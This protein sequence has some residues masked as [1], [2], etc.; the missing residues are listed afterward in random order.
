LVRV[1]RGAQCIT[2]DARCDDGGNR[3]EVHV[4]AVG[5]ASCR[6]GSG[7]RA[8]VGPIVQAQPQAAH[9]AAR[10]A[11]RRGRRATGLAVVAASEQRCAAVAE[12]AGR[13]RAFR[14]LGTR[15]GAGAGDIARACV[16]A[17]RAALARGGAGTGHRAAVRVALD[18]VRARV[19][20]GALNVTRRGEPADD[21][22]TARVVATHHATRQVRRAGHVVRARARRAA[23]DH[24]HAG[25]A[26]AVVAAE[27]AQIRSIDRRR[28]GSIG[29]VHAAIWVRRAI[30]ALGHRAPAVATH[31]AARA[32]AWRRTLHG[33][34]AQLG[35]VATCDEV[36]ERHTDDD[37][38]LLHGLH[39]VQR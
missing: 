36:G 30:A 37:P 9:D 12:L 6:R 4:A 10:A 3:S 20:A 29:L 25:D 26:G 5:E 28:D 23:I 2:R 11:T 38:Q 34:V 17:L 32:I 14:W 15:T 7:G 39:A 18:L 8:E 27:L 16:A 33:A 22:V 35:V 1:P 24:A 31:L 19:L 21:L 13:G